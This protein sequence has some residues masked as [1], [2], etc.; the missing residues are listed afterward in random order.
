MQK[1]SS[2]HQSLHRG[3][4]LP[5]ALLVCVGAIN[6]LDRA[7]LSIA[8]GPILG[9]LHLSETQIGALLS[10]FSFA[11]GLAQLPIGPLLD[12]FGARRV[13]GAGVALWSA[14]QVA[15]RWVATLSGFLMLRALLGSGEAPFYPASVKLIADTVPAPQ[16]GRAMA[17][18]NASAMAGQVIAPPLLT[19][20]MLWFGWRS[21]FVISGA[22][23]LILAALWFGLLREPAAST[24]K[25]TPT[26]SL[27]QWTSHFRTR[28][29]WSIML[30]FGGVNY[31]AWFYLAWLPAYLEK[32]RGISIAHTG[33]LAAVPF[34]AAAIGMILSGSLA[35]LQVRRGVPA[36]R[37]HLRHIVAGLLCSALSSLLVSR[38]HSVAG[39][40]AVISSALFFLHFAGNSGWGFAQ[41]SSPPHLVATVSGIQNFGSQVIGGF[42]P[43][44]TG[45][46]L[47]HTHS[48]VAAFALC[49]AVTT[50]GALSYLSLARSKGFGT[51]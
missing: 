35:D 51:I 13:L 26:I 17:A 6:Y 47:D 30:G 15:V 46:T 21:M 25:A 44:L 37:A 24:T 34:I 12:R 9:D 27:D 4:L 40:V 38:A 23:G 20:L 48:F 10:A 22:L 41:A 2:E 16:R 29:I 39:A 45:W 14:A 5:L 18:V 11:Y 36:A 32:G 33:W 43:F 28:F 19:A 42:A 49:A 1:S 3:A 8:H 50:T 31:A 7:A